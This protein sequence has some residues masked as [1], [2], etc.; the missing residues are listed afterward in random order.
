MEGIVERQRERAY[1]EG[2]LD[3]LDFRRE[4]PKEE[5]EN[6]WEAINQIIVHLQEVDKI[7]SAILDRFKDSRMIKEGGFELAPP[8]LTTE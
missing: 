7:H 5:E 1:Y 8:E 2:F 6:L 3:G 4:V